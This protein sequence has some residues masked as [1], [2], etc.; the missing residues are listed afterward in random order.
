MK[1]PINL[2]LHAVIARSTSL[3]LVGENHSCIYIHLLLKKEHVSMHRRACLNTAN[4]RKVSISH[5]VAAL[6]AGYM[7]EPHLLNQ[8][9]ALLLHLHVQLFGTSQVRESGHGHRTYARPSGRG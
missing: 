1:T 2:D 6:V 3:L 9:L 5:Y 8:I 7:L 4:Q